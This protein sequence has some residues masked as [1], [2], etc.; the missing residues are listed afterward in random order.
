[1]PLGGVQKCVHK[2]PAN[3]PS[4]KWE[5]HNEMYFVEVFI[6]TPDNHMHTQVYYTF[7]CSFL[8]Y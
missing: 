4:A 8:F 2:V 3:R 1:M 7:R 5:S 6:I